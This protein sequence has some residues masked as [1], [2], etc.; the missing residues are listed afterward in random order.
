[1]VRA[2][3]ARLES[4]HPAADACCS[5]VQALPRTV[6]FEDSVRGRRTTA[7]RRLA[8]PAGRAIV[9]CTPIGLLGVAPAVVTT[10]PRSCGA[11]GSRSH[12]VGVNP[13]EADEAPGASYDVMVVLAIAA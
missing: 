11:N 8:W 5:S 6:V 2:L 1:T 3:P 12:P 4:G 13:L 7:V 10:D 9:V